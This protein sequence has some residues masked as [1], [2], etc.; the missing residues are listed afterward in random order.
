M[1]PVWSWLINFGSNAP[2]H[3]AIALVAILGLI[4]RQFDKSSKEP[5]SFGIRVMPDS[6]SLRGGK[7]ICLV[8][9]VKTSNTIMSKKFEKEIVKLYCETILTRG[10][11][12]LKCL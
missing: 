7:L 6:P 10:L 1:K 9:L 4:G 12:I 11:I 5:S 2:S 3:F 8:S